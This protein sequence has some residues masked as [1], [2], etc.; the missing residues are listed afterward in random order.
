MKFGKRNVASCLLVFSLFVAV[1]CSKKADEGTPPSTPGA[2]TQAVTVNIE[3]PIPEV[4]AEAE[5]LSVD[6]LKAAA[7]KYKEAVLAKQGEIEKLLAKI[8][9][10][11]I[12]EALGQEAKTLKT[13]LQ[14]L[15][16]S[17]N[18]L[19]DR[20]QVYY[21]TLKSKGGDVSGLAL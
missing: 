18:A 5:T 9:E 12:T 4:Q 1:G 19:K 16:T 8:K 14:S 15:E 20:F 21:N 3:K 2:Q 13:D 7:L 17:V 11:P 10:I 6:S